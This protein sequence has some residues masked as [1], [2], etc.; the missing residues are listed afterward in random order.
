MAS[1]SDRVSPWISNSICSAVAASVVDDLVPA[2]LG[3]SRSASGWSS[4]S[5][6]T[7]RRLSP[8]H[9]DHV[10]IEGGMSAWA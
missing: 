10:R 9:G 7:W 2:E 8:Q 3:Q 1:A 4:R 6:S 5:V